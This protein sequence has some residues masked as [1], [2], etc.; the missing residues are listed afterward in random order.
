MHISHT[1]YCLHDIFFN[2]LLARIDQVG[3]LFVILCYFVESRHWSFDCIWLGM[4][5]VFDLLWIVLF[6]DHLSQL[7]RPYIFFILRFGIIFVRRCELSHQS[8]ETL[9]VLTAGVSLFWL[10]LDSNLDL[11]FQL[12]ISLDLSIDRQ[13]AQTQHFFLISSKPK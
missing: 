13:V 10:A 4:P 2:N 6:E 8:R 1:K 7:S 9:G 11:S 5:H 3:S 12:H